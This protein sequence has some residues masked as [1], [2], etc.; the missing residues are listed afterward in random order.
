MFTIGPNNISLSLVQP[1]WRLQQNNYNTGQWFTGL[2]Y[3]NRI[4]QDAV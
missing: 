2:K 1:K 4:F 3:S